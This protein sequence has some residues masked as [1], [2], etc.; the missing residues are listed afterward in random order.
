MNDFWLEFWQMVALLLNGAA[1]V[2]TCVILG[3]VVFGNNEDED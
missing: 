3:N 2:Y 1:F